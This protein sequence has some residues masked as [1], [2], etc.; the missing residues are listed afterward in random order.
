METIM[1]ED[2]YWEHAQHKNMVK[3]VMGSKC[4]ECYKEHCEIKQR[5][6]ERSEGEPRD[7]DW[8]SR[9]EDNTRVNRNNPY[10]L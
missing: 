9:V 10:A 2:L 5:S 8:R 7:N 3:G 4:S 6:A 1:K